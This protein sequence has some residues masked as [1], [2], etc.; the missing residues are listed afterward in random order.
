LVSAQDAGEKGCRWHKLELVF[1]H[2]SIA[3]IGGFFLSIPKAV[4][5]LDKGGDMRIAVVSSDK[6][7]VNERFGTAKRFLIYEQSSN[8]L[9]FVGE[10]VSEPLLVDYFDRDMCDWIADIIQDCQKVYMARRLSENSNFF[11]NRGILKK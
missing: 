1:K 2:V 3:M 10:R 8:G 4:N 5:S 9:Q 7:V 6:R 11:S